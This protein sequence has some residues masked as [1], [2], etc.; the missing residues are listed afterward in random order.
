MSSAAYRQHLMATLRKAVRDRE[1]KGLLPFKSDIEI[2]EKGDAGLLS[3]L[4]SVGGEHMSIS[5]SLLPLTSQAALTSRR[6]YNEALARLPG[7]AVDNAKTAW[8]IKRQLE[9]KYGGVR[10]GQLSALAQGTMPSLVREVTTDNLADEAAAGYSNLISSTRFRGPVHA[11]D[12]REETEVPPSVPL[13]LHP[14]ITE[15]ALETG[16]VALAHAGGDHV[17]ETKRL[18]QLQRMSERLLP[19]QG[20]IHSHMHSLPSTPHYPHQGPSR[21]KQ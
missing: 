1:K 14:H 9:A 4:A 15:T 19:H 13:T 18:M 21:S 6:L 3:K 7:G 16:F 12:L 20:A 10:Y 8:R 17:L 11:S 2:L 5:A